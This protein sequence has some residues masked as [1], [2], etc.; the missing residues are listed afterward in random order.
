MTHLLN[1]TEAVGIVSLKIA[2]THERK[3]W[4][5]VVQDGIGD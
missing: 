1:N 2:C 5:D 3:D 4:H